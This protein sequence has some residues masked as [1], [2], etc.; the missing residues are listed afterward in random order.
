LAVNDTAQI[1]VLWSVQ[2]GFSSREA[3]LSPRSVVSL[4]EVVT[5][6]ETFDGIDPHYRCFGAVVWRRRIL[7]S[8]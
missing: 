3:E 5:I 7:G 2:I 1:D 6:K 4:F 8:P